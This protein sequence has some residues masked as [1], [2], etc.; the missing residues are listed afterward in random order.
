MQ[1]KPTTIF[2]RYAHEDQPFEEELK[3][4]L[5]LLIHTG[6]MILLEREILQR[7]ILRSVDWSQEVDPDILHADLVLLLMSSY[8]LGSGYCFGKEIQ[9]VIQSKKVRIIPIILRSVDLSAT[10]LRL[11]QTLPGGEGKP[12]VLWTDH[13]QAWMNISRNIGMILREIF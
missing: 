10:P 3:D 6:Q 8:V 12:V 1:T 2:L 7:E 13:H 11:L 9:Q 4:H 5:A